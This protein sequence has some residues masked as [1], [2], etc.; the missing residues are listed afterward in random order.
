MVS[1]VTSATCP[2]VT[3]NWN[4]LTTKN[5]SGAVVSSSVYVPF[6]RPF[7]SALLLVNSTDLPS[8]T[9]L[10]FSPSFTTTPASVPSSSS[11]VSTNVALPDA[12]GTFPPVIVF[13][14]MVM[15]FFCL[16]STTRWPSSST[17]ALPLVTAL[18]LSLTTSP[19][20]IVNVNVDTV[21]YP[22]GAAVSASEYVPSLSPLKSALLPSKSYA[23]IPP[24][25]AAP[26]FTLTPSRVLPSSR[27]VSVNLALPSA[28][29]ISFAPSA[30]LSITISEIS[31]VIMID[32]PF[33][34][35]STFWSPVVSALT[36]VTLPS[37][38][39]VNSN[40]DTTV[41]PSGATVSLRTYV[42]SSRPVI[43]VDEPVNSTDLSFSVSF[44]AFSPSPTVTP[45]RFL[46][47]S[48]ALSSNVASA[49]GFSSAF[50]PEAIFLS[51]VI[52]DF[53]LASFTI[54]LPSLI[55]TSP[56]V[57]AFTVPSTSLPSLISNVNDDLT[58][59]PSGAISIF[60]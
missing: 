52:V 45:L 5:P 48:F 40:S 55:S 16:S 38:S 49:D 9:F 59:S 39:T 18:M 27:T 6:F 7:S 35:F 57:T 24:S 56:V 21:S 43:G 12:S 23:V 25:S 34:D 58:A 28:A 13:L 37:L 11:A 15:V 47:E 19:F 1:A 22:S 54:T 10:L 17:Y 8:E 29:G 36:A 46:S 53:F 14:S 31:S 51:I 32:S 33:S 30:F 41:Y 50:P 26:P 3:V 2:S 42:P 60:S 44:F 20:S 4:L